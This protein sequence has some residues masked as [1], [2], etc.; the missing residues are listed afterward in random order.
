MLESALGYRT[1]KTYLRQKISPQ[2]GMGFHQVEFFVGKLGRLINEFFGQT[3]FADIIQESALNEHE[4]F[5]LGQSQPITEYGCDHAAIKH[6]F[7]YHIL[8]VRR[9]VDQIFE[10][11]IACRSIGSQFDIESHQLIDG[12]SGMVDHKIIYYLSENRDTFIIDILE[13]LKIIA[14]LDLL[15][16]SLGKIDIFHNGYS[17]YVISGKPVQSF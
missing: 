8:H 3:E 1:V 6:V 15:G 16:M 11:L 14:C 17:H 7:I 12:R 5:L 10:K 2:S 9:N 4:Q 13:I